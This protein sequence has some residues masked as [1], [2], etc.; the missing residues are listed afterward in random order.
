M[1]LAMYGSDF[2]YTYSFVNIQYD[3]TFTAGPMPAATAQTFVPADDLTSYSL[4]GEGFGNN[5]MLFGVTLNLY[6][7]G[8][9]EFNFPGG[10][11]LQLG[12]EFAQADFSNPGTYIGNFGVM[13]LTETPAAT[14]EPGSFTLIAAGLLGLLSV[15]RILVV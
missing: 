10:P 7:V 2:A 14:P 4:A 15:K 11:A 13:K 5:P 8:D 3:V 6:N 1:V 12:D 9:I